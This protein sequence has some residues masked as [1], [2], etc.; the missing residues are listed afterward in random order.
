MSRISKGGVQELYTITKKAQKGRRE[1]I[2][3]E[4]VKELDRQSQALG[5]QVSV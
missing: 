4:G 1:G 5:Q 3:R 2:K